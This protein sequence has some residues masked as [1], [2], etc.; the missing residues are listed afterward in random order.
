MLRVPAALLH[1]E[2]A[3]AGDLAGDQHV[4]IGATANAE[5]AVAGERDRAGEGDQPAAAVLVDR[6]AIQVAGAKVH[7]R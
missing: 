7:S 5:A 1:V 3:G 4:V 6:R 2:T